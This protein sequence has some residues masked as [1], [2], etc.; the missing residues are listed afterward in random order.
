MKKIGVLY[1][2]T[3]PYR[4]FWKDFYDTSEQYLLPDFERHYY[5]FSENPV[6]D[7][8][9]DKVHNINIENLPWPLITLLRYHFFMSIF[10]EL[11]HMD[12]L[13]F[14]NANMKFVDTV[15]E[16]E[17]LPRKENEEDI[18]VVMHPGY[19]KQQPCQ[20]PFERRSKSTA[21]V[22]YNSKEK[23]VI[24]AMNGGTSE[25]FLRMSE[26]IRN[27]TDTDLKRNIIARW[28]DE[29]QLNHYIYTYNHYRML[30][31]SFCY[32]FG[33]DL[34][35]EKKIIAVSKE[36][37]FDVKSFKGVKKEESTAEK[38]E[39]HMRSGLSFFNNEILMARDTV[40]HK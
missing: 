24:G 21:F 11:I 29:S 19:C 5:V 16:K 36:A 14:S 39:R 37:K 6:E 32:P 26:S 40:L 28:H 1:I 9:S 20:A 10:D 3:G 25:A 34:P 22:P 30:S 18:M 7:Y 8:G 31:P 27:S 13:M 38:I 12:Y 2:C 35:V 33:F 23:Y 17:F 4:L 15:R